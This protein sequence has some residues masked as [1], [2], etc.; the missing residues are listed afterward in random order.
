MFSTSPVFTKA[1]QNF[2]AQG[3]FC[4]ASISGV[5]RQAAGH[6]VVER[7]AGRQASLNALP[8]AFTDCRGFFGEWSRPLAR[9]C[10][11]WGS[12]RVSVAWSDIRHSATM[13]DLDYAAP[14]W[15]SGDHDG[16]V[17]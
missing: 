10:S 15:R 6:E 12:P 2:A 11:P 16:L 4:K 3:A 8:N 13:Q 1:I 14:T 9:I 17:D 7:C 5:A